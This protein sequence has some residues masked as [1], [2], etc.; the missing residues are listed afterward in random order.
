MLLALAAVTA[1]GQVRPVAPIVVLDPG[2]DREAELAMTVQAM[3]VS[4]GFEIRATRNLDKL[5]GTGERGLPGWQEPAAIYLRSVG[6]P[7][8]IG[9]DAGLYARWL[10]AAALV[11]LRSSKA[12]APVIVYSPSGEWAAASEALAER[13]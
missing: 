3:L 1:A 10:G 13:I 2:G 12:A 8:E 4:E 5:A 7:E 11:R 6:A 9:G